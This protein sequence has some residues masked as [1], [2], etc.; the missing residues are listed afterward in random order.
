MTDLARLDA[1]AQADLVRRGEATVA[2]LVEAAIER[3]EALNPTINSVVTSLFESALEEARRP[4]PPG[5]LAGVPFLLKDLSASL[6]GVKS[7]SHSSQFTTNQVCFPR[8]Q[9]K[10]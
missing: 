7:D 6:A 10:P 3:I 5:P 4:L 1:I 9:L 2:E 8:P